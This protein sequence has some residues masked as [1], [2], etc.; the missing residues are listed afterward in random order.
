MPLITVSGHPGSGTST[1]VQGLVDLHG[2]SSING[3]DIFRAE[4]KRRGL[5][6]EAFGKLCAMDDE[7]DRSLDVLL[8]EHMKEGTY[9]IVES[10]LAG[11][12]AYKLGLKS[13]RLWIDVDENERAKRVVSR[14]GGTLER[15]LE[16]N[17]TRASVDGQRFMELYNLLPEQREPYTTVLDA[18]NLSK[19]QVLTEVIKILE[20]ER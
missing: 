11:W 20:A 10:R 7:V 2:W 12:W 6:L 4:A 15:A 17:R 3:G 16:A 5:D 8:Q 19:Q 9:S 1:L 13:H 18:T 14:E